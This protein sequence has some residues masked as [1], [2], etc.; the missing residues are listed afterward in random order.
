MAEKPVRR[1]V[2]TG[3]RGYIGQ[4]LAQ[5]LA[6]AGFAL[7]LVSRGTKFHLD[8]LNSAAQIDYQTADLRDENAWLPLIADADAVVHLSSRTDLK[9]AEADPESSENMNIEPL[10]ALVRAAAA[11]ER[12][13][14]RVLFAS[15]VTIVGDKHPN[16]VSEQTPDAPCSLYDQHK[17]ACENILK[18][19]MSQ[20][21]LRGCS[22]R[23]S[24]VYGFGAASVNSNRGILN[25]ML[26]SAFEGRALTLFGDGHYVRDFTHISDVV[27]AFR[28][29][30]LSNRV[31]DSQSY[32]I[33]TGHGHSLA[34]AFELIASEAELRTGRAIEIRRVP[35]PA[36][37]H[38][39]EK[40]N[41]IGNSGLFQELTSWRPEKDLRSGIRDYFD[42][43][44]QTAPLVN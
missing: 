27:E 15:T 35:E 22:L 21:H 24:N 8:T 6:Q 26:K 39:I 31:C 10:R 38:P 23:L 43:A 9:A 44:A 13:S 16:P 28:L 42:R 41:F 11:D 33:A 20:G 37:L 1:V 5:H 18:E 40:R 4:A 17:L 29:A 36:D 14:L 34:E 7:R 30:L 2:I 19:A 25:A 32:V 3:A 12:S